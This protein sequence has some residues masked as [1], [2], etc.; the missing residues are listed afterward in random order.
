MRIRNY[1]EWEMC[2]YHLVLLEDT[3]LLVCEAFTT[4]KEWNKSTCKER[5]DLYFT[6]L[7]IEILLLAYPFLPFLV[8]FLAR[9]R[10]ISQSRILLR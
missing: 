5:A 1:V 2:S 6:L 7:G 8:C 4:I 10:L 3:F 9:Y